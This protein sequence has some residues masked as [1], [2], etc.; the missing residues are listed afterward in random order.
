MK[1]IMFFYKIKLFIFNFHKLEYSVKNQKNV[2][3]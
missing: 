3:K 1:M 2:S